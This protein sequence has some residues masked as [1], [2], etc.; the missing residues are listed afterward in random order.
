[1]TKKLILSAAVGYN[2]QQVE[3]FLKSLRKFYNDEVCILISQENFELA[4]K[5]KDYNCII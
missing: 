4:G 3:F 5:L 2:F 1:M